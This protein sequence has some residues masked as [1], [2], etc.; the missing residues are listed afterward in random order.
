MVFYGGSEHLVKA[1]DSACL[2]LK[3]SLNCRASKCQC[4]LNIYTPSLRREIAEM[5]KTE[6][7]P[8]LPPPVASKGKAGERGEEAFS[9]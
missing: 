3:R 1:F 9:Y 5:A 8:R 2:I 7:K 6:G 4:P